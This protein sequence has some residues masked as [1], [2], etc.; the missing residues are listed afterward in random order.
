MG[1]PGWGFLFTHLSMLLI[2]GGAVIRGAVGQKGH[3]EIQEG[4]TSAHFLTSRGPVK[5]PFDVRLV[6]FDLEYYEE[7]TTA[8]HP[9]DEPDK[10]SIVWPDYRIQT[11]LVVK[12]G[13]PAMIHP[14]DEEPTVSNTFRVVVS[15]YVPDFV[16]DMTTHEVGTRSQDPLNPAILVGIEGQSQQ[17]NKWLFANHPDFDMLHPASE[18]GKTKGKLTMRYHAGGGAHLHN[19]SQ[20]RSRRIRSFK[21]TLQLLENGNV[22]RAKTI[23]V[24]S[25]LN[26]RGYTLYQS[27][28]DPA[29]LTRSTL[30]VVRDPGVRLVYTGFLCMIGG[31]ILLLFF[32]PAAR[33][34]SPAEQPSTTETP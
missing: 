5:M 2:L 21:S 11:Q 31:L 30:Q 20:D 6:S 1:I 12:V 25:P 7:K 34:P 27:G 3:L 4:Q 19:T 17:I 23:E 10:I 29:D 22:I 13:A 8:N 9:V 18:E 28:Y 33:K 26:Y 15:R 32:K 24:N 16:V 14:P